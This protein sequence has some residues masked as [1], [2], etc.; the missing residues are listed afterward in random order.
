MTVVPKSVPSQAPPPPWPVEDPIFWDATG[1]KFATRNLWISMPCL[2][3]AFAVWMMWSILI[4]Q[5][6]NSGF[7]FTKAQLY[8][9]PAIAGLA[10]AT[11]RINNSFILAIAGGRN[12]VALT[13]FLLLIPALGAGIALRSTET[14]YWVFALLAALSGI[15]GGNFASSMANISA[16]Y[17]KSRQGTAL[18]FNAGIG[19]LGVSVMQVLI[20]IV[21]GF[22]LFGAF[23]GEPLALTKAAGGL[24]V[25]TPVW[26][27]NGG[28]VWVPILAGL[29]V[30][31]WWRMDNLP[32]QLAKPTVAALGRSLW[33]LTLGFAA[34]GLCLWLLLGLAWSMWIVLPMVIVITLALMR[35]VTP[36]TVRQSLRLQFT[37][38]SDRHT[39]LMTILYI[40]TFGSFI[41]YSAAFPKLIQ[42]VFGTL[43]DGSINPQA[44]NPF[45]YAWLGP[46]VG[47]LARTVG[48]PLSDRFG[49]AR[50]TQWTTVVMII[51]ALAVA[52]CLT[53]A[54]HA[55]NPQEYFMPFLLLFLLLFIT[56]GIG[57]ASTFRMIPVIFD[58][59]FAGAVLG[60]TS[61]VAAYGAFI[62]PKV[63]GG[64]IEIRHPEY[65]M[66]GF[67]GFYVLCLMVNWWCYARS[68]A[69]KPC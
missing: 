10:G 1:K 48:G 69:E 2:L 4:V 17:P 19:N 57:N 24:P 49:G 42:D 30:L 34:T 62:I 37:I 47:S 22:S 27:Q 7:P 44:P 6:Q 14:P 9:L 60:W 58:A 12:V 5:M 21:M 56:T 68:G 11:L 65:A 31:A 61:A 51:A 54:L 55:T 38:F 46:L 29:A 59:R 39:W 20:P 33:L 35:Y 50:V 32:M 64:L 40:M 67:A 8:T 53:A 26:I 3:L 28:L 18:G 63:F 66:Y 43:P 13:T 16:F 36:V 25:G 23:G 52:W 15:G 41:G 45:T